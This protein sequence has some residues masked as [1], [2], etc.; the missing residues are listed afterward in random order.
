M[1]RFLLALLL[2]D[3]AALPASAAIDH[4]QAESIFQQAKA[5]CSRD[6]GALWGHTLCGPMLLAD[7]DDRDA[8]ANQADAGGVLRQDGNVF[9]GTLPSSA[10][11][12]DTTVTWSGTRWCELVWPW[13]TREDPD[14]LRVNLAHEMWHRIETADLH[15]RLSEGNN[16]HLDTLEGRY[17]M[18]MEWRAL[19][20]ALQAATPHARKRAIQDAVLFRR[21]RYAAFPSAASD[22]LA[23]ESNEGVAEYTGVRLG[24]TTPEE[25]TR[26]ALRDLTALLEAPGLLRSFA[27]ATGPAWGLLL[28]RA[29]PNWQRSYLQDPLAERFDQRLSSALHLP[30]P[31]NAEFTT[32]QAVYDPDGS[33]RAHEVARDQDRRAKTAEYQAELVDGPVLIFPREH[34]T[35]Q[36]KP[37]TL[38]A[39]EHVGTV[40]P[41]MT[42]KD[43]WGSLTV[44]AGG[45]LMHDD[46]QK[47]ATVSAV[48]FDQATLR[49]R[50][51]QLT[52]NPGWSVVPGKRAGDYQIQRA[53]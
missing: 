45:V 22:E 47:I 28:D 30:E 21:R 18:E 7:A 33:L 52:L 38:V 41:T 44:D 17:L 8:V 1:I 35:Y 4:S 43:D 5:I 53:P 20:A 15:I 29:A 39:I 24:L 37:Q 31:D 6:A 27:Y 14:M 16:R 48:G 10:I 12:S 51:L 13:P 50:G 49:G 40:Y 34:S 46:P 32:R 36:F 3:S 26:Y 9:V 23:L 2:L 42:L 19:A 25:R 11:I